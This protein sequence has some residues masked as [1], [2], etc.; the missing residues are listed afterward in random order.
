MVAGMVGGRDAVGATAGVRPEAVLG[1]GGGV[2]GIVA[3]DGPQVLVHAQ[4][5]GWDCVPLEQLLRAGTRLPL[6]I[7]NGAKT[8]GQA[9]LW[10]GA[11]RGARDA[12]VCL[13]G[14][15]VGASIITGSHMSRGP[16]ASAAEWGHTTDAVGGR[17]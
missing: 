4:P 2:P 11:G 16:A 5:F 15:G 13:I 14:S 12:V 8:M 7:Q 9:E 3:A 1:V 10:F 6:H 17:P